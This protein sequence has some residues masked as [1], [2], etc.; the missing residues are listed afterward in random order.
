MFIQVIDAAAEL[1]IVTLSAFKQHLGLVAAAAETV[2][3][4]T[5]ISASV[6][7]AATITI[8]YSTSRKLFMVP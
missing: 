7:L 3:M 4:A 6:F 8:L 5:E 1:V 2:S